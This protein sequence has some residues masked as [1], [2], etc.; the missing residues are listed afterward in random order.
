MSFI[1]STN[2]KKRV[3]MD[4]T[5]Y[6]IHHTTYLEDIPYW[7]T[8]ADEA[9]GPILELGCGTG[10]I[11]QLLREEGFPAYGLDYD[12]NV[13]YYLK[14]QDPEA[15]VFLADMQFFHLEEVFPLVILTCNTYSTLTA[16]QRQQTLRRINAHLKPGG[17]FA[18]SLPSPYDLIAMGD[19]E[20]A[21]AEDTF[22][23]P[24]TGYPVEVSSSWETTGGQV[25]IY[26]HYDHLHPDGKV[27]RTTHS[28]THQ[29]DPVET[30]I[31]EME[32]SG[33]EVKTYGNFAQSPFDEDASYLILAG[34]KK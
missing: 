20:E 31:Q 28:I 27:V 32:A 3:N 1:I 15:P 6:H 4:P 23:H 13:L 19:S 17:V 8:L 29:L 7:I 24:Q 9:Q 12:P 18:A 33:F 21:G 5:L 14:K 2:H 34:R 30:Y 16:A 25:T 10:R 22:L 11:F 26:W